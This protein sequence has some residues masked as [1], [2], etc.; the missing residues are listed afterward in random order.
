[1]E[2]N[3]IASMARDYLGA[4]P[5]GTMDY[6][7]G[8][9]I[10]LPTI[11]PPHMNTATFAH[12]SRAFIAD[13]IDASPDPLR[14]FEMGVGT[15]GVILRLAQQLPI[16]A[17]GADILPM[18]VLNAKA[19]ALWW[20]VDCEIYQSD[21][22]DQVPAGQFDVIL[23]NVP[24]LPDA[25]DGIDGPEFRGGFDPGYHALNRFLAQA[26][27]ERLAPGGAVLLAVD[28]LFCDRGLLKQR[29]EAA[30]FEHRV[31]HETTHLWGEIELQLD[32]I[33]LRRPS[34]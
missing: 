9:I 19:N 23:W 28:R 26:M 32:F 22:F 34:R 5:H 14:V 11:L 18:A 24:W 3:D 29:I 31:H 20:D 13:M 10:V 25:I 2:R 27:T 7:G 12:V 15:G 17:C 6:E 8:Q 21:V 4:M 16:A 1:M 33:A 30:G